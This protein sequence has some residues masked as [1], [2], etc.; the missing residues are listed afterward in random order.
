MPNQHMD[1]VVVLVVI[2]LEM[3]RTGI[4]KPREIYGDVS[5]GDE[6]C[7]VRIYLLWRPG[8]TPG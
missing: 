5:Y 4:L 3:K 7:G 2:N 1:G 6:T 8:N